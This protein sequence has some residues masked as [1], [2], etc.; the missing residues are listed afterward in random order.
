M[1]TSKKILFIAGNYSP[2]PTGIGRY[3]AEMVNWLADNRFDCTVISTYP[4]YPHWK[5][6]PPYNKKKWLFTKEIITTNN[7]N[8]ITVYRCPHYVPVNPTGK[9]RILL[10]FS[11]FISASLKLISLTGK[12][13]DYIINVTPPL[14]LGIIAAFYKKISGATFLYHIQDLQVDAAR[15][16]NLISS[17]QLIKVLFQIEIHILKRADYISTISEGMRKK[18]LTKTNKQVHL[19][20]NWTDTSFFFPIKNKTGLKQS[21]GLNPNNPVIL[22]SGAIGEKQGLDD[23]LFV[24]QHFQ[25]QNF[26]LQFIICGSGPYKSVLI[27]KAHSLKLNNINFMPLQPNKKLNEFLNM[28]D[29]HLVI[30][31]A[32]AADLVMPSKLTNILSVGGLAI[33]TANAGSDLYEIISKHN[34][35][36]LCPAENKESLKE[37]IRQCF[38]TDVSDMRNNAR[39]YAEEYLSINMVMSRYVQE[40]IQDNKKE[41]HQ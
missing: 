20:P 24:A 6:Q 38:I 31:K 39:R 28:A 10:D 41:K 1:L 19:F 5:I 3:N 36:L 26:P 40:T 22:Y 2:E 13:Y 4:Y 29:V 18:I 37:S 8:K 7:N 33:I 12:R 17:T 21:F 34:I 23:I 11:Y 9:K 15:D 35:G 27:E 16:L 32:G 30:Q 25:I 14:P